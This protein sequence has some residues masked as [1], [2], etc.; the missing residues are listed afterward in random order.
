MN[1]TAIM[2]DTNSGITLDTAKENG[3]YL[4]KMPFIVDGREYVEYGEMSYDEFFEVLSSGAEVS[5]SQPSPAALTEM[6]DEIL[7]SYE[8]VVYFPM[9]SGLS[10]TC[11]TARALSADYDGRVF[12]V[13]NK[14]ISVT[15][16]TSVFNAVKLANNGLS[17]KEIAEI[18]E[19]E[20]GEQSVYVSVNTLEHLKKSGRVTTAGAAIGTLLGI[21]PVLQIQGGKLDA[22]KKVRGMKAAT[23]AMLDGIE[24]DL[25]SRFAGEKVEIRAAYSG[26]IEAGKEWQAQVAKRFPDLEIEL[27]AL[28]LSISCHVGGGALGIGIAKII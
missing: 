27:D 21:K 11:E 1:K 25:N 20:S 23:E 2:T 8:S 17:A 15:L 6:W 4:L 7:K 19:K 26:D 22:Y 12:V 28:P 18:A 10:G 14:R 3:I 5:T 16:Y 24:N 13:D 9:S